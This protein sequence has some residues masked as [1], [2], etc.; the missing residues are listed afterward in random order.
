MI[1]PMKNREINMQNKNT[2]I[3]YSQKILKPV[4]GFGLIDGLFN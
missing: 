1:I 2:R 3:G 4:F